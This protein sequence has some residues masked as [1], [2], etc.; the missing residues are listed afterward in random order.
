MNPFEPLKENQPVELEIPGD[1]DNYYR[2]RVEA[3]FEDKLVV[4]APLVKGE[5]VPLMHGAAIKVTYTDNVAIYV[6]TCEIIAVDR[7][8]LATVTL[9]SPFE[10]KRIQRRNF[11]RLDVKL[12]VTLYKLNPNLAPSDATFS[13]TTVDISGGGMMFVTG[14]RP[15]IGELLEATLHLNEKEK[16]K[17]FG[18]VIRVTENRPDA[19]EK[20]SVGFEFTVIG[21]S[22]RDLIIRF[23]FNQQRELRKRGLL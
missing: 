11:V 10:V 13:A 12:Q 15:E 16:I 18:R 3:V 5:L 4:A 1:D 19:R 22:A 21:E 20:F 2:S 6:F 7:G 23:I 14:Y 17:A 9:G 8:T